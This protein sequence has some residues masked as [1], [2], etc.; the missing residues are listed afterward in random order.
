MPPK[1]RTPLKDLT[2]HHAQELFQK[3]HPRE[4]LPGINPQL[5][6]YPV[7]WMKHW[8]KKERF[9]VERRKGN[10]KRLILTGKGKKSLQS[11]MPTSRHWTGL[12]PHQQQRYYAYFMRLAYQAWKEENPHTKFKGFFQ[13]IPQL[14]EIHAATKDHSRYLRELQTFMQ[15]YETKFSQKETDA[16]Q[17]LL[18]G[19]IRKE[20]IIGTT[21]H[22]L[23]N[24][25]SKEKRALLEE[26]L[27][28]RKH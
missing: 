16:V 21:L 5:R 10:V 15:L 23:E 19:L 6:D 28:R 7:E 1:P 17:N 8:L 26:L 9:A 24:A 4:N 12:T 20:S 22:H 18:I 13:L 11:Q 14:E 27:K 2:Q 25:P 3:M